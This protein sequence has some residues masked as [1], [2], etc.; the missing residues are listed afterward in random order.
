MNARQKAQQDFDLS[1]EPLI[2]GDKS[3]CP[4]PPEIL[5]ELTYESPYVV[6]IVDSGLTAEV[7]H[8]R[9]NGRDYNMK[10][11]RPA[12]KVKNLDGQYSF[13][14][15]VQRRQRFQQLREDPA[16][17][18][19]FQNIVPTLYA[20]YRL[21]FMISPWIEGEHVQMLTPSIIK[22]LFNT[23]EACEQHGLM[24]WDLCSGNLLVD[25]VGKL[26]LFDFGYMYPFDP[27]SELN[28]NGLSDPLF[29]LVER[30]ETR[31]FFGWLL[32]QNLSSAH[33]LSLYESVK[34]LGLESYQRKIQW[35]TSQAALP[36]VITHFQSI[37]QRWKAALDN[38][39]A[40]SQQFK[41]EAF[42]SYV[43]DIED[44]LHG[45]SC[46]PATLKKI[47][48]VQKEIEHGYEYLAEHGGLF[49]GN[50]DKSQQELLEDYAKKYQLAV[51]YQIK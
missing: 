17:S 29:H 43:L 34:Q 20:D 21:G 40:L 42:R 32:E 13:L 14:N 25:K 48:V 37:A 5:I 30:F 3:R 44:D 4:L 45:Q 27:L 6:K 24:E 39:Q 50:A 46:T 11:R 10:K 19:L 36:E 33:Q 9:I 47:D 23:L 16:T 15:E 31:F 7:F 28:S 26:W 18:A 22:Q 12:A 8:L 41:L 49:Y 35:L 2:V 38:E 1:G 51:N